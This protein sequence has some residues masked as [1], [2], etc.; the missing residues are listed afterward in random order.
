[1]PN[2]LVLITFRPMSIRG[3]IQRLRDID[4]DPLHWVRR[5]LSVNG[6]ALTRLWGRDVML[7]VGGVSFFVL[8]AVFPGLAIMVGVYSFFADAS[9]AA[10]QAEMLSHLMPPVARGLF[11]GELTRLARAPLE[12]VSAQSGVA[13][14]IG[15]YASHRG[16]KALLAG[17]SFIHDDE[18]PRGFVGFNVMALLVLVAAF[19]LLGFLSAAFFYLRFVAAAFDIKPLAGAPWLFSEWTWASFGITLAMSLIY[20]FAMSSRPV[21][22]KASITGGMAAAL[23]CLFMSWASA[24]YVE[25]I[26]QLGATYGS[27]AAVVVF[28]IWLSWTVNAIF[29][30]GALATEIELAMDEHRATTAAG[31]LAD[32]R[33]EK[34]RLV[35]GSGS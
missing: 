3:Q 14:I 33:G 24:F 8:L 2:R 22:W 5:T 29:F 25:Q 27:V 19:V 26:A 17:L 4:W 13:L 21:A 28:L 31:L 6:K 30:G 35:S 16:F 9:Q 15:S 12:A 34:P 1:M 11:E 7:Y 32:L 23:L 10:A 18:A 20:R